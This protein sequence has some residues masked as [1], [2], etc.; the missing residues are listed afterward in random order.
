[1][2]NSCSVVCM[3]SRH[4]SKSAI[5]LK[6]HFPAHLPRKQ[7]VCT[8]VVEL[9]QC[10]YDA[11]RCVS[12]CGCPSLRI[13][14]QGSF[15]AFPLCPCLLLFPSSRVVAAAQL[16]GPCAQVCVRT[17][18]AF[19][20][21]LLSHS[22]HAPTTLPL[23]QAVHP[24]L[25]CLPPACVSCSPVHFLLHTFSSCTRFPPAAA[26]STALVSVLSAHPSS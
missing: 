8:A 11:L 2:R 6:T 16:G 17:S 5:T 15:P 26:F 12:A 3:G 14:S 7:D 18:L 13:V 10:F 20:P 1:M 22:A 4:D 21:Q 23:A 25:N 19:L 24:Q 9:L